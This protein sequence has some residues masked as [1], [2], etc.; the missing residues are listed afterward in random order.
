M[1]LP[2][3]FAVALFMMILGM[4][5]WGSWPNTYKLTR[6]WRFEL[7]YWD[8]ALGIFLTSILV[9]LTLGTLFG[10][11]T[12]RQSFLAADRSAWLYALL[13]G[14]VWNCGNILL[15]AGVALVGMAV[16]F[17]VAIGLALVL[18]VIGSYL[19]M[20]RG[21]PVLLFVGVAWVFLAVILNSLAYRSAAAS[22][23]TVSRAGLWVCF[24]AGVL[25][26]GFGPLVG[27]AL[28]SP[29]P[30]GPYGI[31][32]LFTLGALISTGPV[33]V[34]FMRHPVEGPPLA[35][36]DYQQGTAGQHAAGLLGGFIWGLGTTLTFTAASMVGIALAY[37]IGQANPL[38]AALWGVF[39]WREFRGAP[40]KSR[41]L[42][43]VMFVLYLAGLIFLA[44]SF[45]TG[46]S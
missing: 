15:V 43:A 4:V 32:F 13:A 14:V 35:R 17:P 26:S 20:P 36:A 25:F 44:S 30:L 38:V 22:R 31:T 21:N 19:V 45:E 7:F 27:K 23:P 9:A 41:I 39:V 1:F 16:A 12:F 42:L 46:E 34:Y 24:L 28:S 8:Y 3:S 10:T 2:E 29:N 40:T 33:M 6:N 11:P 18:G 5:F 37:A